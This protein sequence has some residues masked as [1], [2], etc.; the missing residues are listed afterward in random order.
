[1]FLWREELQ[2]HEHGFC[3][4]AADILEQVNDLSVFVC[5]SSQAGL[6]LCVL[7]KFVYSPKGTD[8]PADGACQFISFLFSCLISSSNVST[9]P[10]ILSEVLDLARIRLWISLCLSSAEMFNFYICSASLCWLQVQWCW[11]KKVAFKRF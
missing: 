3:A 9:V 8:V 6:C 4:S 1:M 7:G 5:H 10:G 11:R 2:I